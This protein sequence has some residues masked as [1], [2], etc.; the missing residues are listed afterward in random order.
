[1]LASFFAL[2]HI[3]AFIIWLRDPDWAEEVLHFLK[4]A[5]EASR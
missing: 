3:V 1:L 5:E 4:H 2:L